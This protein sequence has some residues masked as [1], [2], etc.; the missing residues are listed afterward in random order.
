MLIYLARN[1]RIGCTYSKHAPNAKKLYARADSNWREVRSTSG[2]CIFLGGAVISSRCIRQKCIAM[3]ST[4]A[5][6]V[7]LAECVIELVHI[8]G[9]CRFLGLEI[10]EAV[11]VETDNKGAHDLCHRYSAAQHSKH[12]DRKMYKM[13]EMRGAGVVVVKHIPTDDN[14]AD[15]FTKVLPPHKFDKHRRTVMNLL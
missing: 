8:I 14:P 3:S 2:Y 7:A 4:E 5:E 15:M 11:E 12:I 13:R 10:D 1:R 6:L 9:L